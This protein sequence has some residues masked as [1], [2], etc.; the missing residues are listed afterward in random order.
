MAER[1]TY[2]PPGSHRNVGACTLG[3]GA[4]GA[5][6]GL[7]RHARSLASRVNHAGAGCTR[8]LATSNPDASTVGILP[9]GQKRTDGGM[10][11]LAQYNTTFGAL[12]DENFKLRHDTAGILSMANAVNTC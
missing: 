7:L 1:Q 8:V 3:K 11:G 9:C 10:Y 12:Q 6:A 4:W 2:E 5:A